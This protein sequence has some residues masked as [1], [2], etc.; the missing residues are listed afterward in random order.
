MRDFGRWGIER[1]RQDDIGLEFESD[2]DIFSGVELWDA[3]D[4]GQLPQPLLPCHI[5]PH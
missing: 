2:W 1:E 4:R 5:R 3:T